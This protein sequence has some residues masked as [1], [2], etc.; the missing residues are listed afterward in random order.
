MD[1]ELVDL[2]LQAGLKKHRMA[3][4]KPKTQKDKVCH[5]RSFFVLLIVFVPLLQISFKGSTWWEWEP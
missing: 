5:Y 4:K 2:F 3:K 1:S